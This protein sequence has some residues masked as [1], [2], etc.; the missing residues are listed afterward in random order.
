MNELVCIWL[1]TLSFAVG[2]SDGQSGP[3][4]AVREQ[5][6]TAMDQHTTSMKSI[7]VNFWDRDFRK[8]ELHRVIQSLIQRID[9]NEMLKFLQD[10]GVPLTPDKILTA[11]NLIAYWQHKKIG[12]QAAWAWLDLTKGNPDFVRA[13]MD[14]NVIQQERGFEFVPMFYLLFKARLD[15]QRDWE[16]W[17]DLFKA[18]FVTFGEQDADKKML[19]LFCC[20]AHMAPDLKK[21]DP[22]LVERFAFLVEE[23]NRQKDSSKPYPQALLMVLWETS[24]LARHFEAAAA[25]AGRLQ[26]PARGLS[27]AFCMHVLAKDLDAATITLSEI[28]KI[29]PEDEKGLNDRRQILADLRAIRQKEEL[30]K[31]TDPAP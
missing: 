15:T 5:L 7:F 12:T 29:T 11:E 3:E 4:Q 10:R 8:Y 6:R 23:L 14:W 25:Y 30:A 26:P 19:L 17:T 18:R 9:E 16:V 1:A 13:V 28:E 22:P 31:T 24:L 21:M 2:A 20:F 27:L